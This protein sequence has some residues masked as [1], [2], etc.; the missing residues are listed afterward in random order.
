VGRAAAQAL[1]EAGDAAAC[2]TCAER[3]L[4]AHPARWPLPGPIAGPAYCCW[5]WALLEL[6]RH[7]E[8]L[9]VLESA[10]AAAPKNPK[11]A[12]DLKAMLARC[13][14]HLEDVAARQA[15]QQPTVFQASV[16][17]LQALQARPQHVRNICMLAHVDHGKTSLTD[18]LIA[19]NRIISTKQAGQLRYMDSREDEQDR[20]ITMKSSAIS[21]LYRRL[22]P[23]PRLAAAAGAE[24][25][26]AP[27]RTRD[28]LINL[29]DSPGHIDFCSEVS[30]AV[31][32]CDGAVVVVDVL[33]G[34][35]VQTIA[36]LRQ[37]W[38]ERV[39]TVLVLN[40]MDRL[41]TELQLSAAE[42][43]E[44]IARECPNRPASVRGCP[45]PLRALPFR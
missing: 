29:I 13:R 17:E 27:G 39:K 14:Q 26:A 3:V 38:Q 40:K 21:L 12:E 16:A 30:T 11:M 5:C 1:R 33:E 28:Y 10:L 37:A 43:S 25:A 22:L 8:A 4:V 2:A 24:A 20:G 44:H 41:V 35:C 32:I 31:R 36:V 42:A 34:V 18:G 19:S 7:A 9:P 6:G 23:A 45:R 15:P